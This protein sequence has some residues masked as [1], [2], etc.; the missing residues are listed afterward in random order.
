ALTEAGGIVGTVDYMAP[1]QAVDS[2]TVDHRA[3]IYSLGCTLFYLLTG[4]AMYSGTSLMSLLLQ[5][6]DAPPPSLL[7]ARPDAPESVNAIYLR[8]VEK[9]PRDRYATMT[10]VVLALEAAGKSLSALGLSAPARRRGPGVG[11]APS[12]STLDASSPRQQTEH[13]SAAQ[14]PGATSFAATTAALSLVDSTSGPA[15]AQE[16]PPLAPAAEA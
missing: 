2:T 16:R 10:E 12:D 8:M 4:R 5:H 15:P 3:D 1:E 14:P 6:R 9:E 13:G 7:E 11:T